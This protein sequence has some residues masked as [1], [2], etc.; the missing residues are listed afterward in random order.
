MFWKPWGTGYRTAKIAEL[1]TTLE[2]LR[3][4]LDLKDSRGG[5]GVGTASDDGG[6]AA[7][8]DVRGGAYVVCTWYSMTGTE[9]GQLEHVPCCTRCVG[10]QDGGCPSRWRSWWMWGVYFWQ[11]T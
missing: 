10:A 5:E 3:L 4:K 8:N 2:R 11:L 1:A 6:W 9:W 7:T